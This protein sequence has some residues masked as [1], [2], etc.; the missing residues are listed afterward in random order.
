MAKSDFTA[1]LLVDQSPSEAFNNILNVREWW[2]AEPGIE[3]STKKIGDEFIYKYKD[4]HYS[5][6]KMTELIPNKKVVWTVLDSAL[7]FLKDKSEWNG[8][9][10]KFEVAK[11]G[12]KTEV[13]FTHLGLVP[14]IECY[15]A[16]SNGWSY[17]IN[18]SL[19]KLLKNKTKG[20]II[21]KKES[22]KH[23]R[24]KKV[25]KTSAQSRH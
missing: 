16:C 19:K 22:D 1:T 10:F 6:Q 21:K 3:G 18:G 8:T 17:Y 4:V 25:M 15:D 24:K 20:R 13:R 11:K 12:N 7:N 5:K 23:T 14:E 2:T 9:K